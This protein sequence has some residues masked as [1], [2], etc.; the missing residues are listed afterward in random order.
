MYKA[1]NGQITLLKDGKWILSDTYNMD[2]CIHLYMCHP[3]SQ[4]LVPLAKLETQ[5]QRKQVFET[6]GNYR[7]D[8]HP[9]FMPD[10]RTA[11]SD[12]SRERFGSQTY[13]LDIDLILDNP[14]SVQ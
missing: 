8:L 5:L 3:P 2:G 11:S 9:R 4:R 14:P 13:L 1:P 10:G 7:I 12:S 6:A